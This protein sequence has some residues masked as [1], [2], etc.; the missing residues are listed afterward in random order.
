MLQMEKLRL[1]GI[2]TYVKS[3]RYQVAELAFEPRPIQHK[4]SD[5]TILIL[6]LW[7]DKCYF[8]Q[9]VK[10]TSERITHILP[11]EYKMENSLANSLAI[12]YTTNRALPI[13]P[14][15]FTRAFSPEK[16]KLV[17]LQHLQRNVHS[18][19]ISNSPKLETTQKSFSRWLTKPWYTHAREY[20]SAIKK[21]ARN[22]D[23]DQE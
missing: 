14:G 18:V 22:V 4:N 5:T 7:S 13:W 12:S 19:F 15:N 11:G 23:I 17:F 3:Y 6:L 1:S 10:I 9:L 2:I 20:Y 8:N 16:R 21:N